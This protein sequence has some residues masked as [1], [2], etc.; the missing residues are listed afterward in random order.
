M[1][2]ISDFMDKPV[3]PEY[4][5]MAHYFGEGA[6]AD[7]LKYFSIFGSVVHFSEHVGRPCSIRW[8]RRMKRRFVGL[9]K[10]RREARESMDIELLADIEMGKFK[11]E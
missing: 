8:A 4:S 6:C 7:F 9:Q 1:D 2:F 5:W 11:L 3:S 10:A